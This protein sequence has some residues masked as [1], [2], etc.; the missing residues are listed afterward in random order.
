MQRE[1][2]IDWKTVYRTLK[3]LQNTSNEFNFFISWGTIGQI[4][5]QR[6]EKDSLLPITGLGTLLSYYLLHCVVV[7]L[8]HI[9]CHYI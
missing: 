5:G 2:S 6:N 9:N 4:R 7:L 3:I 1:T 8:S